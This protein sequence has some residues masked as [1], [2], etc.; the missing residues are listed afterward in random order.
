MAAGV[1]N[2]ADAVQ[3]QNVALDRA[4]AA[5]VRAR[6]L[7]HVARTEAEQAN[8]LKDQFLAVVSHELRTP[9]TA[10]LGWLSLWRAGKLTP[11]K[12]ANAL[13]VIER[14]ARVQA[15]LVD[16]LLDVGRIVSGK[17]DIDV[18]SV[19]L[20]AVIDAAADMVRP[21]AEAAGVRLEIDASAAGVI[22]GDGRRLMQVIWNL[23]SNAV[24]FTPPGGSVALETERRGDTVE[25]V[26]TD[27]GVGIP[28]EFLPH[29]FERFQQAE[30]SGAR[31]HGG[32]GLGL[33]IV[34]HVVKA[35]HGDVVVS[36]RGR[37]RGRDVH[38]TVTGRAAGRRVS[39][40]RDSSA[41]R[42]CR[43]TELRRNAA[44]QL[45]ATAEQVA[46]ERICPQSFL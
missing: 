24:K 38:R 27:T 31:K 19:D 26:V 29:V 25:I 23:L 18:K 36:E 39:V 5:E 6:E 15:Q 12:E 30:S 20:G 37:G 3:K 8:E 43:T 45:S 22:D 4:K 16:D 42:A 32:L 17:L 28:R 10:M 34:E 13:V 1:L 11:E 2:R 21:A 41:G 44:A 7:E 40:R 35:H 33:S 46:D 9:L 14:N